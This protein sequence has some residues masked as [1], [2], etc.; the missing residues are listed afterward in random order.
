M[1]KT[2]ITL[3]AATLILSAFTV[4]N[5]W[6]ADEKTTTVKWEVP[7]GNKMGTFD[8]L[9]STIVFDKKNL[10]KSNVNASIDVKSLKAGNEKMEAHLMSADYF[11]AEKFPKITFTSS[12]IAAKDTWYIAKGKLNMKDSTKVIEFPFTFT[13]EGASKGTF[14]G[15]VTVNGADYGVM[16]SNP[17]KPGMDKVVIYLTVP[18]TK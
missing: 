14:S 8:K 11:D 13:E 1:K 16:K 3:A 2:V 12:E 15:T 9:T 17:N 4:L 10:A 5:E 18:V 6:K 7:A